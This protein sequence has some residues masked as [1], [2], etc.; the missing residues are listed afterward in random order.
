MFY[1][2]YYWILYIYCTSAGIFSLFLFIHKQ[3]EESKEWGIYDL[4]DSVSKEY[5]FIIVGGGSA[6]S[7]V[8]ARLAKDKKS[9]VLL[10]EAGGLPSKLHDIPVTA[11]MLQRSDCDW[12]YV[13]VPQKNACLGLQNK[14]SRWPMGK[15]LGGTSRLNY[16]IYLR[17][18]PM[19]YE[20]WPQWSWHDSLYYFKKSEHHVGRFSSDKINHGDSGPVYVSDIPNPTELGDLL[21][22]AA[23]RL[24]YDYDI[25][26]N[27][28]A[29]Y[30]EG[31]MKTQVTGRNGARWSTDRV[32]EMAGSNLHIMTYT[33]VDKIL[34]RKGFEAYGVSYQRKSV[35]GKALARKAVVL[36]AGVIGTPK[37]LMLS[38]IGPKEELIK[39][40]IKPKVTLSVGNNLQD[41]VT[42][43]LDLV[44]LNKSLPISWTSIV[45]SLP[46]TYDYFLHGT[47]IL[48]HP[49][50]DVIGIFHTDG[51]L[52]PD[53]QIMALPAGLST[54]AG[55]VLAPA[56]GV[57]Q[58]VW[59]KYFSLFTG[60]QVVT[61]LP[62]LLHPRSRGTVKLKSKNPN[63]KPLIDPQYLSHPDDVKNLIKGIRLV[64]KLV[65]E[66]PGATLNNHLMPGCEHLQFGTDGYWECYLRHLTL[67]AY[68]PCCTAAIGSVVSPHLRVYNTSRLYVA[69][70]SVMPSLT[71][72]NINSAVLMIAEKAA[73]IILEALATARSKC[74]I[75]E[76]FL[77]PKLVLVK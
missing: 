62:V 68:H 75:S 46:N 13:T 39:H 57:S 8:A 71:S 76:I 1:I 44:F 70:A 26:L 19:D 35:K 72:G 38:G 15:I 10:I 60:R 40:N 30:K 6:G 14:T 37:I 23:A 64:E 66:M 52:Q 73:D 34:L 49:G 47:G 24:G 63:D 42:T 65:R 27:S 55:V 53:I 21:M 36:S 4:E 33:V 3:C 45:N 2:K 74:H 48:T 28:N 31:F 7:L 12:Q 59:N 11:P 16:M 67:T 50:T 56:M 9:E 22:K 18:H 25:D 17:G 43:G 69:D 61:L 29:T 58:E 41:H 5:D 32:L 54:D 77:P 20:S 51:G